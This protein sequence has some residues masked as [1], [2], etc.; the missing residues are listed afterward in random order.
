MQNAIKEFV[1]ANPIYE[2]LIKSGQIDYSD[3]MRYY[4]KAPDFLMSQ[5][6]NGTGN[7][8]GANGTGNGKNN[9]VTYFTP[10]YGQD[11]TRG[12]KLPYKSGGYS[13]KDLQDAGN[14]PYK[15]SN[16]YDQY[17]G[18]YYWNGRWY[19]VDQPKADYYLE[20]GTY[21]GYTPDLAEY[22]RTYGT[23]RGYTPNWRNYGN[24][25]GGSYSR[26]YSGGGYSNYGYPPETTYQQAQ[27]INNIMKN[28]SF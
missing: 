17:E 11:M 7:G 27:R 4:F 8:T 1:K 20:N 13:D 16:G 28:W 9:G 26:S 23:Y 15:G 5:V 21:Q 6:Q 10:S 19:P 2:D 25:G 22:Y 12:V 3:L 14:K 18:Y 24:G